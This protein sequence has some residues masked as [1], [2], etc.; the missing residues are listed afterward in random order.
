MSK[1]GIVELLQIID[2]GRKERDAKVARTQNALLRL[3][4]M[5][6]REEL[7]NTRRQNNVAILNAEQQHR[8]NNIALKYQLKEYNRQ[9]EKL[10]KLNET[11]E[12]TYDVKGWDKTEN[13]SE[14][15]KPIIKEGQIVLNSLSDN[16]KTLQ[17]KI[18]EGEIY[19]DNLNKQS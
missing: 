8:T 19:L 16:I 11:I 4:E 3:R 1:T 2:Q 17:K 6:H 12:D 7:E 14:I 5:Q 18:A 9:R 10:A 15:I 13:S